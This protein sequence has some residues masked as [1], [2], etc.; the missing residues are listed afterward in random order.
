MKPKQ[1]YNHIGF[2]LAA[3]ILTG[4]ALYFLILMFFDSVDMIM[5]NFFSREIGFIIFIAF[6]VF[7]ANRLLVVLLKKL[8]GNRDHVRTI[9]LLHFF[10]GMVLTVGLTS[11]IL[12]L[13]FVYVEGFRTIYTELI[14]FNSL[15][16]FV[17]FFYH[18][19]YF[20]MFYLNRENKQKLAQEM[21]MKENIEIELQRFKFQ[22]NP[23]MLFESLEIIISE[24]QTNKKQADFLIG[25]LSQMYRYILDNRLN[26]L[27]PLQDELE[28]LK[29]LEQLF[30]SKYKTAFSIHLQSDSP[31]P[32]LMMIPGTLCLL[33]EYTI[34]KNI[35]TDTLPMVF[36]ISWNE[37]EVKI[38][39]AQHLRLDQNEVVSTRMELL[40]KAYAHYHSTGIQF[41]L[42]NNVQ[43][44]R[45]PLLAVEEE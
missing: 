10:L 43:Q 1:F 17:I 8:L 33:M 39:Y 24:L 5:S 37:N 32:D 16:V 13:Y 41:N 25:Q 23:S 20:G 26:D 42:S 7:E 29:P 3:P 28:S 22:I 34:T 6:V 45:I 18:L 40:E 12:Y 14:T 44:I 35:I 31:I 30:L 2:R 27:V 15:F 38:Q 11:A 36:S 21:T 19:Y 4:I 9:V